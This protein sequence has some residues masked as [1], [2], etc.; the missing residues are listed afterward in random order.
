VS[1][2]KTP[3]PIPPGAD[4]AP[5][6]IETASDQYA[7]RFTG[8]VGE[9]FVATQGSTT[10]DLLADLP[11]GAR[12]LDVGGGHAQLTPYL[13][14]A[15][16]EVTVAGSTDE[17][18]NRVRPW[19]DSGR[20]QFQR[21]DLSALPFED[22]S[23]GAALAF[24]L[25]AHVES[26]LLLLAE[27][28]RVADVAVIVDYASTRSFNLLAGATFRAKRKVEGDTRPFRTSTPAQVREWFECSGFGLAATQPQ[29]FLPMAFHRMASSKGVSRAT[30][31][32]ARFLQLTKWFGSPVIV[33]ADRVEVPQ[34]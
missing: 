21:A 1:T 11:T 26:P 10:L 8:P 19:L 30:E 6:D 24:R 9:W 15:G 4:S 3:G 29:F 16:Y 7:L 32:A 22:R 14:E 18:A 34:P 25:M 31:A 28:C 20:C 2:D 12:V 23:F 17:C 13:I 5:P 27:L 33:R